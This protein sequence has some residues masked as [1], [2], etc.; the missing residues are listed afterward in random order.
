MRPWLPLA[1]ALLPGGLLLAAI[2]FAFNRWQRRQ[3]RREHAELA[4]A[5]VP[6]TYRF[7]GVDEQLRQ[8]S[9]QRR[10]AAAGIRGRANRLESGTPVSD[11]RMVR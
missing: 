2:V 8:R 3:D 10:R 6:P 9:E 5:I 11:L 4:L 1:L 7:E